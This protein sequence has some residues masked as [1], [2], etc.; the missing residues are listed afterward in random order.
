[1][2]NP[3]RLLGKWSA[4]IAAAA[5]VAASGQACP[6]DM[7]AGLP[8]SSLAGLWTGQVGGDVTSILHINAPDP[9]NPNPLNV[10]LVIPVSQRLTIQFTQA[11][12]PVALLLPV[13]VFEPSFSLQ[14][15]TAFNVGE[16]QTIPEITEF[17]DPDGVADTTTG[18]ANE[19]IGL[20][21]MEST[22]SADHFRVVYATTQTVEFTLTGTAPGFMG[23][24]QTT[25]ST[26]TL[27]IDATAMGDFVSFSMDFNTNGSIEVDDGGMMVSGNTFSVGS[28]SGLL[29]SD[30]GDR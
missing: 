24:M 28:L 16:T 25:S 17:T 3:H 15:V 4:F 14:A 26:G 7:T 20:T 23:I 18:L 5:L 19:S 22:L 29:A 27:T 13:G 30:E 10:D 1:M 21:V 9:P 2:N 6:P 11:G 8:A 12:L